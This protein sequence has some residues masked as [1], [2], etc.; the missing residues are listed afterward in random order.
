MAAIR[1]KH[2]SPEMF[3]RSAL[4]REGFRFRLHVTQLPGNPDIVLPRFGVAVFVHGCFW[5]GHGCSRAHVP[6]TN[7]S[8]WLPKIERNRARF[9]RTRRLLQKAGWAVKVV[10][11]CKVENETKLLVKDLHSTYRR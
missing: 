8:Y 7:T 11:E 6:R 9:K 10:H 5:H 2:T 1:S 4:H 3:V